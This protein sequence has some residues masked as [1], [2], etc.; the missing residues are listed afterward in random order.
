MSL[1]VL[2]S[3]AIQVASLAWTFVIIRRTG[4]KRIAFLSVMISLMFLRQ[5]L[6]LVSHTVSWDVLSA[7]TSA[8]LPGLLISLMS[9]LVVLC[10]EGLITDH[11]RARSDAEENRAKLLATLQRIPVILWTTD[12]GPRLTSSAGAGLEMIGFQ[13]DEMVGQSVDHFMSL[14][15]THPASQV[16][17]QALDGS[18]VNFEVEWGQ[19]SY[20]AHLDPLYGRDGEICGCVGVALDVTEL[21]AAQVE[22]IERAGYL[23]ALIQ[24]S[25]MAIVVLDENLRVQMCNPAF[26]K[27]FLY[28]ESELVSESLDDLISGEGSQLEA[29]EFTKRVLEGGTINT[30]ARRVRKDGTPVDVRVHGV[31]LFRESGLVAVYGLYEDITERRRLEEQL[32]QSQKMEALGRLAGGIS[33]DFNNLLT[34]IRGHS[35]ILTAGPM[36]EDKVLLSADQI[37]KASDRAT[38]LTR[39]LLTFSRREVRRR[40]LVDLNEAVG[41]ADEILRS[42]ISEDIEVSIDLCEGKS[43]VKVDPVQ[44]EQ[45]ILNLAINACEAMPTGGELSITTERQGSSENCCPM[46]ILRVADTGCGIP[47]DIQERIFEPFFTT[48][49]VGQGTGLGLSTVYG[50]VKQS[51]GSI[52]V[53]SNVGRG[54]IFAVSLPIS[55]GEEMQEQMSSLESATA[56][57]SPLGTETILLAE[58]EEPV[59]RLVATV[60]ERQGYRVVAVENPSQALEFS[61]SSPEPIDLLLTDVVMP[62]MSGRELAEKMRCQRPDVKILYVSGYAPE[63]TGMHGVQEEEMDFLRKPFDPASLVDKVRDTLDKRRMT[64]PDERIH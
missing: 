18:S 53:E 63:T 45:V 57:C 14:S 59:R 30:D 60:L 47:V 49:E 33:H 41:H 56:R 21:K 12:K 9:G 44:L 62:G 19:N 42:L 32:R 10:L 54:T 35:D 23:D 61:D 50:I 52:S 22:A 36:G 40:Q 8:Q 46:A 17:R 26:E 5:G 37:R 55:E 7:G 11:R 16:H 43:L 4:E 15:G 2:L 20:Q 3:L 24:N 48:R 39:Q 31:P 38:A 27:L 6:S 13:S 25:P 28:E 29:R 51:Q 58:D 1:I 34:V 64:G